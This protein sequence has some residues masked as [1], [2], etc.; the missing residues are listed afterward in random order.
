MEVKGKKKITG[1]S[2]QTSQGKNKFHKN[3][4]SSSAKA[5]PRKA[6]KEGGPKVT[7]K[8]F[9]KG[10]TKP[11]KK[12]VKQFKNKP[13]GGKGPKDKFQ[14]ANKFNKKRKFQPDGKSDESAAKKPKW[15]DFKRRRKS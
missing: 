15:D 6:A 14:K 9:E 1:K 3:S 13:Q 10:A 8:N 4:E 11:G 7:S 5:F 2:P 12:R